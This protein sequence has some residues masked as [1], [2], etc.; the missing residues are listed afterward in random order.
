[1]ADDNKK[2]EKLPVHQSP[3][4]VSIFPY[5]NNPDTKYKKEGEYKVKLSMDNA[6][7]L[8]AIVDAQM[9][10]AEAEAIVKAKEATKK[11]KKKVEAKAADLPYYDEVDEEGDETGKT[12]A[13]FKST[14]S[15]V[16][17]KGK[18]WKRSIPLFDAKGRAMKKDIFGGSVLIVAYSAKPWVNPK[19]EYGVKL[20]IEA[21]QVVE[22][23][24]TGGAAQRS[25]SGF[26]FGEQ[27]GYED[28]GE[29]KA[30]T[31]DDEADDQT[32]TSTDDDGGED[33]F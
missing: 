29:D 4:G 1:M 12:V 25:A 21:A 6:D 20:Q 7:D 30:D 2:F 8:R 3:K 13:S 10:I 17:A 5:L 14:A 11:T 33:Q 31:S 22:L 26:G 15:G 27:E 23:V 28:D 9:E 24:S 16:T 18:P 32:D 19:C